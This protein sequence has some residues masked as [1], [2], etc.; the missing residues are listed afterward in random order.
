MRQKSINNLKEELKQDHTPE[1]LEEINSEIAALEAETAGYEKEKNEAE[2]TYLKLN[3]QIWEIGNE[4]RELLA[5]M[6]SSELDISALKR[7]ISLEKEALEKLSVEIEEKRSQSQE[8]YVETVSVRTDKDGYY[9]F[10]ALPLF[11]EEQPVKPRAGPERRLSSLS[12]TVT[13]SW[14][15]RRR[16]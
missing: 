8:V 1:E 13:G 11:D 3:E 7:Q 2:A 9:T 4:I 15:R 16:G 5:K 14:W 10:P 12:R 6:E